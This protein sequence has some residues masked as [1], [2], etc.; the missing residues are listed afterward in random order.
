MRL[1]LSAPCAQRHQVHTSSSTF[2]LATKHCDEDAVSEFKKKLG[3][4]S[5]FVV[6]PPCF[7]HEMV[8]G[9]VVESRVQKD[10]AVE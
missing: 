5:R 4:L 9:I 6:E 1:D 8:F 10:P 7:R 2:Q 3:H